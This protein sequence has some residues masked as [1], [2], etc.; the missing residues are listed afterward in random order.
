MI[1]GRKFM[2]E[3]SLKAI[4]QRLRSLREAKGIQTQ[5]IMAQMIGV[6]TNRYNNWER[7]AALIGPLEAIKVC[8][9]TGGNMDYIFRGEMAALPV[10][11]VTLLTSE[12]KPK[13]RVKA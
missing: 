4:G 5:A 7:G 12:L 10:N 13:S 3:V 8:A 9:I 11:L 6:E 2:S 1:E